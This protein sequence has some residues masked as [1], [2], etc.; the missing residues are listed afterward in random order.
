MKLNRNDKRLLAESLKSNG[1]GVDSDR[2]ASTTISRL[3]K[4]GFIQW[5]PNQNKSK[6]YILLLTLTE[7]GKTAAKEKHNDT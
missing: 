6:H 4:K 7:L 1:G 2:Y 3:L 5:K